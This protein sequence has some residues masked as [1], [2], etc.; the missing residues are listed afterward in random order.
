[1][2]GLFVG[3]FQPVHNGHLKAIDWCVNECDELIV[4]VGSS[5]RCYEVENPFTVG[6]RIEMLRRVLRSSKLLEKTEI[7]SVPDINNH[8]LWVAHI[9]SL[10][11]EYEV[12]FSNNP[13]AIRLFKDAGKK[14]V[15]VPFFDRKSND[16][17][18]IRES[19]VKNDEW[20]KL[21]PKEVTEFVEERGIIGR[22]QNVANEDKV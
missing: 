5:Q 6:E 16:G 15:E 13:L 14:C 19:M 1:M 10:V 17:T 2:R 18:K 9:N 21:V 12:V 7:L 3:R 11:P 8:A 20:K 4:L 22:V